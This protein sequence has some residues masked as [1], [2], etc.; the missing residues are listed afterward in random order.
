MGPHPVNRM[1]FDPG[2]SVVAAA[3][4][5]GVAKIYEISTGHITPLS[6]H[7]DAVQTVLFD[8]NGEYMVSGSSDSTVKVWS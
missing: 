5:D 3:S 4:N 1:A 2:S 8:R 6:S 7:D